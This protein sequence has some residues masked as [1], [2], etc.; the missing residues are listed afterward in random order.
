[1]IRWEACLRNYLFLC[2]VGSKTLTQF[3]SVVH[4]TFCWRL[5]QILKIAPTTLATFSFCNT[6]FE[7][8]IDSVGVN[9][10]GK[11]LGQRSFHSTAYVQTDRMLY[12]TPRGPAHVNKAEDTEKLR[13]ERWLPLIN[14]IEN[15]LRSVALIGTGYSRPPAENDANGRLR[16][17]YLLCVNLPLKCRQ[18]G[19][20][21]DG[22]PLIIH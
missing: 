22:V 5:P 15:T 20:G 17:A 16:Y 13:S 11:Y 3:N 18:M 8:N 14:W 2:K 7:L 10:Q 21:W 19:I 4:Q 6:G 9:K 1:V 12:P